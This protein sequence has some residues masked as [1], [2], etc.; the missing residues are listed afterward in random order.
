M[1]C[2]SI[3]NRTN[4]TIYNILNEKIYVFCIDVRDRLKHAFT[5]QF[6]T[7]LL[8]ICND[9]FQR[10]MQCIIMS[11]TVCFNRLHAFLL[12]GT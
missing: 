6:E 4:Q 5:I 1:V 2:I 3:Q 8:T 12:E 7:E 11:L 10:Q 9:N